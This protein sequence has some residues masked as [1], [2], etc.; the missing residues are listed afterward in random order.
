MSVLKLII[1]YDGT[2][3]YGWQRQSNK[4][5]VQGDLE[6]VLTKIFKSTIEIDGAGRTDSGVHALGQVATF[7]APIKIPLS[8]LKIA[9][10]NFL[11]DDVRI[12]DIQEADEDFHARYSATGKTYTYKIY[13]CVERNVFKANNSY[14]YPYK[15]NDQLMIEATKFLIGTHNFE[16]F[17]AAGSSAQNPIRTIHNITFKRNHNELEFEFTG[18]GFLYKMVRILMAFLLE[19]GNE[20][21][22]LSRVQ[23]I[24]ENPTR[25]FTSKVAPAMGLY[26]KEVYYEKP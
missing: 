1:E 13:N 14:H 22:L 3:F 21:I 6:R 24:L 18:D 9:L 26:L 20:R 17:K 19:I 5:S 15:L 8:N 23:E 25:E 16:S 7:K 4:R 11:N 10:N 12:V 2:H